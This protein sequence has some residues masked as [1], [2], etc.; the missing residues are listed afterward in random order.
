MAFRRAFASNLLAA[1]KGLI[2][3]PRLAS[4]KLQFARAFSE[5]IKFGQVKWFDVTKGFGFIIPE[6]GSQDV[7]VHQTVIHKDGFRSL[8]ENEHVEYKLTTSPNGKLQASDV[9]GPG[10]AFVQGAQK[11]KRMDDGMHDPYDEY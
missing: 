6:D 5:D 7:F 8:A 1:Q 10:G 9:T 2:A 11:I 4:S 3:P